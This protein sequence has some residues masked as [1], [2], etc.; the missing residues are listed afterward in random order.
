MNK[1]E[2]EQNKERMV[3]FEC[4]NGRTYMVFR[5]SCFVCRN[6]DLFWDYTNGPY[7]CLC[8]AGGDP[9]GSGMAGECGL[10]EEVTDNG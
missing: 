8:S 4:E 9:Q 10:Y 1:A 2:Y 7:L 3:P 5:G 6:G